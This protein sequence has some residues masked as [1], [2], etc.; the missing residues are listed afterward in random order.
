[1]VKHDGCFFSGS[2]AALGT[3]T[4]LPPRDEAVAFAK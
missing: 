4:E 2:A 1:M 3:T